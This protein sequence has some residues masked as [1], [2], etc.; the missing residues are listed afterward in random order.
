MPGSSESI[1]HAYFPPGTDA[2]LALQRRLYG[3]PTWA[4]DHPDW[5]GGT[6][7]DTS[8]AH[9]V[10]ALVPDTNLG[11]VERAL[12]A[13]HLNP[14]VIEYRH[15]ERS[16]AQLQAEATAFFKDEVPKLVKEGYQVS[17]VG[18]QEI[19]NVNCVGVV[20][21]TDAGRRILEARYPTMRF[22]GEGPIIGN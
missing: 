3:W 16:E 17:S 1:C 8:K 20:D 18:P 12:R 14:S 2:S 22:V 15:V 10:V 6:W 4:H 21:L 7:I 11:A 19:R 9:L 5:V 13:T